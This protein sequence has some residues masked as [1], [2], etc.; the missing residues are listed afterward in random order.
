MPQEDEVHNGTILEKY[1]KNTNR[2]LGG[3][4][5]LLEG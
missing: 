5:R 2:L 3:P 4:K 1:R